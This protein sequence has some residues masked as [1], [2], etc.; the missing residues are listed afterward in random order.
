MGDVGSIPLGFLAAAVGLLGWNDGV[1]PLWCPLLV[2]S[3]FI[4][5]AS[6]T[7][8]RR[9]RRGDRFW[10]PH[11]EHYYQRLVRMGWSH[12]RTA[13]FEYGLMLMMGGFALITQR[14]HTVGIALIVGIAS[15]IYV[16]LMNLVDRAWARHLEQTR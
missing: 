13:L 2:F 1:W 6:V 9:I 11:R 4:V 16:C 7:L 14:M 5:D 15:I 3:P 8:S 10:N 12:K